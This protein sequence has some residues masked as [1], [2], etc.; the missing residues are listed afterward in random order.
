MCS[1]LY[2]PNKLYI[3]QPHSETSQGHRRAAMKE[4]IKNHWINGS[5]L[6]KLI[7]FMLAYSVCAAF[8]WFVYIVRIIWCGHKLNGK[9]CNTWRNFMEI[10]C[11]KFPQWKS[12][13][14]ILVELTSRTSTKSLAFNE[15]V[16]TATLNLYKLIG[17]WFS[18]GYPKNSAITT[19]TTTHYW[20][21]TRISI[22]IGIKILR[23]LLTTVKYGLN[24]SYLHFK[25]NSS[26][27]DV[28]THI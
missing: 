24:L 25:R 20:P 23:H 9:W 18:L 10:L 6:I 17:S 11:D 19:R 16:V 21:R 5:K 13:Q 7:S 26:L 15:S 1:R 27:L 8:I 12:S 2:I 4:D 14:I 22:Q 3:Q 28:V